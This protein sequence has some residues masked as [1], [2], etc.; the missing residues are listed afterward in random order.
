MKCPYCTH[1]ET[2]VIDKRESGINNRRRRECQKCGQRFTTYE[3]LESPITKVKR[4]DGTLVDFDQD[5]IT[6]AIFAAAQAVGGKDRDLAKKLSDK[7]IS[8]LEEK[9]GGLTIPHVE[10]IQDIVEKILMEEGH[11]KTAKAYI[12]YRKEHERIRKVK[13]VP[14][15]DKEGSRSWKKKRVL[16]YLC[17]SIKKEGKIRK[18]SWENEEKTILRNEMKEYD[19]LFLNP[20]KRED[21]LHDYF[22][23]F[24]RDLL[25]VISSDFVLADCSEERG[26][27]VGAEMVVAK[28]HKI[29]LIAII[30]QGSHY[31]RKDT[32]VLGQKLKEFKHAF[33]FGL[34]D[35]VVSDVAAAGRWIREFI[36]TRK[37]VKDISVIN[38]AIQHYESTQLNNDT[39]MKEIMQAI[40]K[41]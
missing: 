1:P 13:M 15:V 41:K 27:G 12:L 35:V 33:A 24:G 21:D 32:E 28:L 34:P 23:S 6:N 10:Q 29:P 26:I 14:E 20:R 5:R 22:S 38:E 3:R 11:Y 17:G 40:A 37:P 19:L 31:H 9:F 30:P 16:I 2:K 4:R 18:E 39:P 25:Q 36:K 8:V 7:V